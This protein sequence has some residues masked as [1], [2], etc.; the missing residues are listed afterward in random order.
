MAR[1]T[2]LVAAQHALTDWF[3]NAPLG[4]GLK[5]LE[6][7]YLLDNL[8][9]TYG[10]TLV[11]V[12]ALGWEDHYWNPDHFIGAW[13]L[14]D[15][16]AS[17]VHL[18]A[19]FD[20]WPIAPESL[21]VVLLPHTLELSAD[22]RALLR[23]AVVALKPEG[24]LHLLVFN[25]YGRLALRRY[26]PNAGAERAWSAAR[27]IAAHRLL[28]WLR[29]LN[30][31]AELTAVF[32]PDGSAPPQPLS[33]WRRCFSGAYAVRAIKRRYRPLTVAQPLSWL[34]DFAASGVSVPTT[35]TPH[36]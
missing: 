18:R 28:G 34:D 9:L 8:R 32:T 31:E 35:R 20:A 4:D 7:A 13:L 19:D 25:P 16:P 22:P 6:A 33:A 27:C 26:W 12:G 5:A 17:M 2:D 24:V 14:N 30:F 3:A 23:E 11:Q 15:G 21:D 36:G 29:D 10:Q 1:P